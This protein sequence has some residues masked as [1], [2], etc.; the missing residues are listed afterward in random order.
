MGVSANELARKSLS[1]IRPYVP[2]K[3][4]EVLFREKSISRI[5]K[6]ASNENPFGPSPGAVKAIR[7]KLSEINRYPEGSAFALKEKLGCALKIKSN[8]IIVGSG[9]SEII[10]MAIQAFCEPGDEII[11]P[12][13]SF[14]IYRIL[15]HA[16]GAVP[17]TIRLNNDMSYNMESFFEKISGKTKLVILCNP[18][19]P[20]GSHIRKNQL[21]RFM[22]NVPDRIVVLSDEAY[23]EYVEDPQFG[24]CMDWL[25]KKNVIVTRTF[26][27]IYGLAGLRIG[28]GIASADII[29]IMEKIRPPFNTTSLAQQAALGAI[30]DHAFIEKSLRNNKREKKFLTENLKNLRFNVFPSEANFLFCCC[31]QDAGKICKELEEKGII[32]RPMVGFGIKENFIRITIGKPFENRLLIKELSIMMSTRRLA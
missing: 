15:A 10:N 27:K 23:F 14:I 29:E 28:Y 22:K 13:P 2:G 24:T 17:V 12:W 9:S 16:H 4:M 7:K 26:S 20:T 32:V 18:N 31:K 30:D 5:I 19:N 1:F 6:L 8:Q 11:F 3:P 25:G 21:E